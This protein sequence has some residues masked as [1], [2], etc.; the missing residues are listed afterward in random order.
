MLKT[1]LGT[2][3]DTQAFLSERALLLVSLHLRHRYFNLPEICSVNTDA[4]I[5]D[6]AQKKKERKTEKESKHPKI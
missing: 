1:A 6:K 3:I 2:G 5:H 4:E